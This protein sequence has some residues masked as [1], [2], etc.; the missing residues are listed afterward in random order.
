[1]HQNVGRTDRLVRI[2]LGSV[3][4]LAGLRSLRRGRARVAPAALIGSGA[5]LLETAVTRVCPLNALLGIDTSSRERGARSGREGERT[6][7]DDASSSG[8]D[9]SLPNPFPHVVPFTTAAASGP[10]SST[11]GTTAPGPGTSPMGSMRSPSDS[12]SV[13]T[14][15]QKVSA[16]TPPGER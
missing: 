2:G 14:G 4:T 8:I 12:P 1:M 7:S 6:R 3:L 15:E 9:A 5:L 13:V 11:S 16:T 10:P